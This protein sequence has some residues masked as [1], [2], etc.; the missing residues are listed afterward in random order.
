M[1]LTCK[2]NALINSWS[3]PL[4]DLTPNRFC[5]SKVKVSF[6]IYTLSKEDIYCHLF[7]KNKPVRSELTKRSTLYYF[8]IFFAYVLFCE[9]FFGII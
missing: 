9:Y 2:Y 4:M 6:K 3:L 5:E 8:L 7:S 1:I